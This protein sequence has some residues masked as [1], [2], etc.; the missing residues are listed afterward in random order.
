MWKDAVLICLISAAS[1]LLSEGLCDHHLS[2]LLLLLTNCPSGISYYFIYRKPAY[3]Q[4]KEKIEKAFQLS[5]KMKR[6][7]SDE[8]IRIKLEKEM[9]KD[10]TALSGMRMYSLIFFSIFMLVLYQYLKSAYAEVVV[11][12]LPFVPFDLLT[13]M[14]HSGLTTTDMTDCSF[15]RALLSLPL[16]LPLIAS[17]GIHLRL[18][19]AGD[20]LEHHEGHRRGSA[21]GSRLSLR[22][23]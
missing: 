2:P 21:S 16:P 18:E 3:Q 8:K 5:Q 23:N 19:H 12:K 7:G 6:E 9:K 11:A 1:T 13:R 15:V 4:L 20:S 17:I 14:S 22:S 10:N